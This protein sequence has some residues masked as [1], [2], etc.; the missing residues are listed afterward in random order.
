MYPL[1]RINLHDT[2]PPEKTKASFCI[3]VLPSLQMGAVIWRDVTADPCEGLR[4][5]GIANRGDKR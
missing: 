4:A 1:S 5:S 2:N 3:S